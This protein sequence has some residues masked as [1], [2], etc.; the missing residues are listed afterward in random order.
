M[1]ML[2]GFRKGIFTYCLGLAWYAIAC[3]A[4]AADAAGD[5]MSSPQAIN[6]TGPGESGQIMNMEEPMEGGM[7]K[8]GMTK[9]D[10]RKSAEA[11]DKVM[12]EKLEG[13]AESMP[14]MP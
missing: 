6:A 1:V 8:P 14:S 10:V 3:Q 11:K 12:K 9:G 5:T 2:L 13:E 7:M 4:H